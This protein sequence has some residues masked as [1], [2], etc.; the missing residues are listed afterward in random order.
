MTRDVVRAVNTFIGTKDDGNTFPGAA[1][2]F[3][4]A[5]SSPIGSHYAGYRYDD[6]VIRGFGHFFLSGAGC[7][8]QG[9]LVSVLPATGLPRVFDHRRYGARYSHDGEIGEAGYYR[10]RLEGGITVESTATLRTGVERFAFPAGVTPHVLVNVGQANDKEPVFASS[11]EVVD[12][13]TLAGSVTSQAFC[14]GKPYTTYFRTT[15]DRPFVKT[16]NWGGASGGA[17]LRGQWVTFADGPVT[18]ATAL[19]HVD[20]E[21]AARNLVEARGKSFDELRKAAQDAW[22]AELSSVEVETA[23]A[24]DETVF[25]TALYH[26]LLQPLT[27]N[28]IDGRYRGFDDRVHTAEGWTYYEYFSLWDTYRAHN[29]L[30]AL[31]RPDRARDIARSLLAVHEQGGWLPRWAYANQETNTMTGDPVTPFLVDLWRF[32]ALEGL[33]EQAYRALLQNATQLPPAAS[34]FEGRAGVKSYL[35]NGFVQYD[36]HHRKKGQDVDPHHGASATFEYALADASLSIMAEALGHVEDAAELRRRGRN[37]RTLWDG[38]VTDRGLTGFP[39]PKTADGRWLAEFTP[40]GQDGFHE[41]T[42]WQYQWLVQQDVPGLV[43]LLGGKEKAAARLDDFFAYADLVADPA[44]TVREKWVVGPYNY[45]NQFRYNP[46]NEPDLHTPWMYVLIGQ[47]WKTSAVNRAAQHLFVNAP[48]GVT[49]NDDLGTMSA[50]YLFSALGL[51]PAMPGTG[52]FLLHAPRYPKSTTHLADGRAITINAPD[53][54]PAKL[55][56]IKGLSVNGSPQDEVWVDHEKLVGGV[57]LDVELT[58]DPA[59]ATWGTPPPSPCAGG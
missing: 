8:E 45:Y 25:Y 9:G 5:Q 38:T 19:S 1:V 55:Q 56:Y 7:W 6:P 2:P 17:G 43:E 16:G 15:F 28:D 54:T 48:N 52:Q 49:G 35:A 18:V 23:S 11:I 42:A 24:D 14:G 20:A 46:N 37:Y 53:A 40:Q 13:R 41:G 51:Y 26:V 33:E 58:D 39:R 29:Q 36:P 57:V 44:R 34:P 3:G 10:V 32:G 31:L 47:P 22:R 4:M 12:D 59:E 21:G 30:L 27:G 50:W